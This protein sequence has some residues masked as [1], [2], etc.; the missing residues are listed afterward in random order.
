M[1]GKLLVLI[2]VILFIPFVLGD[3]EDGLVDI[4]TASAGE[5]DKIKWVGPVTADNIISSRPFDSLDDLIRVS[6]IGEVKLQDIKDEGM[7]CV[8]DS[9]EVSSDESES[10]G[11]TNSN[12]SIIYLS[13]DTDEKQS[14]VLDTINLNPKNIN[15]DNNDS[16]L[17]KSDY[18]LY[19]LI[20]FSIFIILLF[21]LRKN[22]YKNEF[23]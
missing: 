7:A 20:A 17:T 3:C 23:E 8:V 9:G 16:K 5:L 18:A 1:E 11:D 10:D 22:K 21:L 6:G 4:N 19:G 12:N 2:L 14:Q 15:S 13:S